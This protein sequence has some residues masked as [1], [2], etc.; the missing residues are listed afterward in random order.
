M[1]LFIW[2]TGFLLF[3]SFAFFAFAQAAVARNGAQSAAD[4]A[5]LAAS[6]DA[7]D[8][9]VDRLL[10]SA[11]EG[12]EDWTDWLEVDHLVGETAEAAAARLAAANDAQ[13]TSFLG[14]VVD[15]KDGYAVRTRSL[16][17]VGD[18]VLPMTNGS[19][20]N[21]E[22]TAVIEPLC[23]PSPEGDLE[24]RISFSCED[25][26]HVDVDIGD[27]GIDDLPDPSTLFSVYLAN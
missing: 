10:L 24:T 9:L 23:Q 8:E 6:Q 21:A 4:A 12:D 1:P 3:V 18:S 27:F 19:Y 15:G 22:A 17:P 26:T 16:D 14:T 13:V 20:A 5:A 2:V 25:G 11:V 7:R